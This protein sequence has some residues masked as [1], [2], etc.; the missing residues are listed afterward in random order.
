MDVREVEALVRDT[1]R[2]LLA[3]PGPAG[4]GRLG[5]IVSLA[6][7]RGALP[8]ALPRDQL[9]A[10]LQ[11]LADHSD[12]HIFPRSDQRNAHP[13]DQEAALVV[14][15]QHQHAIMIDAGKSADLVAG[16][17]SMRERDR[18]ESMVAALDDGILAEVASLMNVNLSDDPQVLRQRLVDTSVANHDA[19]LAAAVQ[20]TE[21]GNLLYRAENEPQS[22]SADEIV[23]VQAAAGRHAGNPD[24][25][26]PMRERAERW[27]A[28][29]ASAGPQTPPTAASLARTSFSTP[30]EAGTPPDAAAAPGSAG[31]TAV[32]QGTPHRRR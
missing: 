28:Q 10:A 19:W 23:K 26:R 7:L 24:S 6:E 5:E 3:S 16:R 11:N 12:V 17:L 31:T 27:L 13:I 1:Y 4:W 2:S 22:L 29:T 20:T 30:A 21:D 18:A 15:G 14:G 32:Q 8:A 25:W 9:D